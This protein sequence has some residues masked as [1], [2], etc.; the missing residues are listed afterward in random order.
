LVFRRV[1]AEIAARPI[2]RLLRGDQ[3]GAVNDA[4][5]ST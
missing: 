5:G 3:L 4:E 2:E 1:L